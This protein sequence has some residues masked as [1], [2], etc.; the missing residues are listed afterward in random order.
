[1]LLIA[2]T[3]AAFDDREVETSANDPFAFARACS[4]SVSF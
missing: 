1:M 4:I 3:S 2:S